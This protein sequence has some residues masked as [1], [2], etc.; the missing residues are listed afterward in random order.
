MFGNAVLAPCNGCV[1]NNFTTNWQSIQNLGDYHK[2]HTFYAGFFIDR[3]CLDRFVQQCYL[4]WELSEG[5]LSCF[6]KTI[7]LQQLWCQQSPY[8]SRNSC[9][10][11][12]KMIGWKESGAEKLGEKLP[13]AKNL[14]K[15]KECL[16]PTFFF[17]HSSILQ[18]RPR[19]RGLKPKTSKLGPCILHS[20]RAV[21]YGIW[22]NPSQSGP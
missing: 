19:K 8:R 6:W 9:F 3:L 5:M 17:A 18:K 13:S 7:L 20:L 14:A 2:I 21:N 1:Q 11:W 12:N 16:F 15:I 22:R 4:I 10:S